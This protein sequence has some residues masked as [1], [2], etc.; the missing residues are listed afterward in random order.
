[1]APKRTPIWPLIKSALLTRVREA[2]RSRS[3]SLRHRVCT[4]SC[5]RGEDDGHESI[6]FTFVRTGPQ[7]RLKV[8]EDGDVW[9]CA[10]VVEARRVAFQITFHAAVAAKDPTALVEAIEQAFLVGVGTTDVSV[11]KDE[12]VAALAAFSPYDIQW[13]AV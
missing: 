3:K 6:E 10:R 5:E 2:F 9:F 8:W 7:L 4:W 11:M 13:K 1:M 12:Y